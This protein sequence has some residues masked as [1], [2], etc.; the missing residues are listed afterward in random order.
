MRCLALFNGLNLS[1]KLKILRDEGRID[2]ELAAA[3]RAFEYKG[4]KAYKTYPARE[5]LRKT[6]ALVHACS[7]RTLD[8]K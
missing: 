2:A 3:L 4:A 1:E 5:V 7:V 6:E 8:G